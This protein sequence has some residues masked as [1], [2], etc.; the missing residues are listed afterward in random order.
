MG[1]EYAHQ[2]M[3]G[4]ILMGMGGVMVRRKVPKSTQNIFSNQQMVVL[5]M[6]GSGGVA[7]MMGCDDVLSLNDNDDGAE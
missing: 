6:E 4:G 5:V 3:L 1:W 7:R 2:E